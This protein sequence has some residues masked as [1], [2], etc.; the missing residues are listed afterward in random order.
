MW[1]VVFFSQVI[2]FGNLIELKMIVCRGFIGRTINGNHPVRMQGGPG[3]QIAAH[4]IIY[5]SMKPLQCS[6]KKQTLILHSA[7]GV[8]NFPFQHFTI[9]RWTHGRGSSNKYLV[10]I[11]KLRQMREQRFQNYFNQFLVIHSILSC[12]HSM[13]LWNWYMQNNTHSLY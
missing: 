13:L 4:R 7:S 1:N 12:H 8:I 6:R 10:V 5:L 3:R 2:G 9:S 11:K